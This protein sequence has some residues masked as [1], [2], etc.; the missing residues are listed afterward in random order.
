MVREGEEVDYKFL[1]AISQTISMAAG[2]EH[3]VTRGIM[4]EKERPDL[5]ELS[6]PF[7]VIAL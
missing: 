6:G 4:E 7:F 3:M 1:K 2:Q 5:Q